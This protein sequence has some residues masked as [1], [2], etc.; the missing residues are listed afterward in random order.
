MAGRSSVPPIL[1]PRR[2]SCST[3]PSGMSLLGARMIASCTC[4]QESRTSIMQWLPAV[5]ATVTER[6]AVV[7]CTAAR[8]RGW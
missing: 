1:K 7:L 6:Q 2:N 8:K 3:E 4:A 5:W